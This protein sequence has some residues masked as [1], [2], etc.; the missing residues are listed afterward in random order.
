[1]AAYSTFSK[2]NTAVELE[3][4]TT[5]DFHKHIFD[6]YSVLQIKNLCIEKCCLNIGC[7]IVK[8]QM[9]QIS[10]LNSLLASGNFH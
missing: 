2:L 4:L 7:V 3:S 10:Q 1:M 6:P 5:S 8:L 9:F